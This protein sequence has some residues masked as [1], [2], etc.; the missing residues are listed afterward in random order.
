M[1]KLMS[2]VGFGDA[3]TQR[4]RDN[5]AAWDSYYGQFPNALKPTRGTLTDDNIKV[6]R[7]GPIVDKGAAYLFGKEVLINLPAQY[8]RPKKAKQYLD[9]V[10]SSNRKMTTLL[11]LAITGGVTGTPLIRIMSPK[12]G[13]KQ[14][15]L[16]VWDASNCT[17]TTD[18]D[19]VQTITSVSRTYTITDPAT[20]EQKIKRQLVTSQGT[21][22]DIV[23]QVADGKGGWIQT[24]IDHWHY[25][26]CPVVVGQNLPQPGSPYGLPDL[27]PAIIALNNAINFV[28]SN[29]ARIIRFHGFPK[30]IAKG[31]APTALQVSPDGT[32]FIPTPEG[33]ITTLPMIDN[34]Q[35]I[36]DTINELRGAIDE[37][38]RIPSVALGTDKDL[39]SAITGVALQILYEPLMEKTGVK[40]M[41][42]GDLLR[43]LNS[44][45][46]VMGGY[47]AVDVDLVWP[48]VAPIDLVQRMTYASGLK[49][50]GA[51]E[52]TVFEYVGLDPETEAENK[53]VEA[54]AKADDQPAPPQLGAGEQLPENPATEINGPTAQQAPPGQPKPAPNAAQ[55]A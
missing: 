45:L 20:N 4:F 9:D 51:S 33:S 5:Q 31:F 26:F 18:P 48:E 13:Q 15:R 6:N 39:P 40:R 52:T 30:T 29:M 8:K 1:P 41:L 42:Y 38:S 23:E 7:C 44:R 49:S 3:D 14:P 46:L 24:G 54:E 17:I 25:E 55:A 10:W 2:A 43:E 32:L 35:S 19:D 34:M 36:L 22:W 27:A 21:Q 16:V 53:A 47:D 11:Q 37:L 50:L 28:L 12:N